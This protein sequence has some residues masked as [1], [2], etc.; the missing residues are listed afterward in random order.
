MYTSSLPTMEHFNKIIS[1]ETVASFG[2][3]MSLWGEAEQAQLREA[4]ILKYKENPEWT[5]E[6]AKKACLQEVMAI[7]EVWFNENLGFLVKQTNHWYSLED[8]FEEFVNMSFKDFILAI[9]K[10]MEFTKFCEMFYDDLR[11][12]YNICSAGMRDEFQ[13]MKTNGWTFSQYRSDLNK[14]KKKSY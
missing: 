1:N 7:L 2:I 5:E 9:N 8:A 11:E 3:D 10:Q 6:Q 12:M 14:Q 13:R 4:M